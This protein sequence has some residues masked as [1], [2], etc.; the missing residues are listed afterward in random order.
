MTGFGA[1]TATVGSERV[2][3]ELRTVNHKFCEVRTHLPRELAP[4]EPGLLRRL[5]SEILRGAVEISIRRHGEGGTALV[6]R[7][8]LDLARAY[9]DAQR[10]IAEALSSSEPVSVRDLLQLEG[11]VR[12]E[13]APADLGAAEKALEGA[14][15]AALE[16]L[17]RMR[18][19][20][21]AALGRDLSARLMLLRELCARATELAPAMVEC[22]RDRL[23]ARAQ[24][25]ARGIAIPGD[26]LAQEVA[27]AAERMDVAEELIRLR[28]HLEQLERL[29][30]G[31][32]A[33]GRRMDFL[34]QELN[35]EIN[36]LGSKSQSAEMAA[37]VVE[38]KAEAERLREQA[39]N[40]E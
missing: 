5:R 31:E 13:D 11:V 35:R 25:L 21:G 3:V 7:V 24:E 2:D 33:V 6:A 28:T 30:E 38:M 17:G 29:L 20:E 39:Q 8:D 12:I 32:E 19:A 37:L 27:L 1:G 10:R 15:G 40:V 23:A 4:L 18:C 34:L 16:A 14:L 26:R 9:A 36:T 22:F